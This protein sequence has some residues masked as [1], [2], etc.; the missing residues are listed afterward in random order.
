MFPQDKINSVSDNLDDFDLVNAIVDSLTSDTDKRNYYDDYPPLNKAMAN[1]LFIV[2]INIRSLQKH[3]ESLYEFLNSFDKTTDF[4]CISETRLKQ[5]PLI[6]V[7]LP[8]FQ[9][10]HNDSPTNAGGVAIYIAVSI[11]FEYLPDLQIDI[12]GCENIWIKLCQSNIVIVT[13]YRHPQ[14]DAQTFLDSLDQHLDLLKNNK[15][16]LIGDLNINISTSAS[17]LN[18]AFD[19]LNVLASHGYFPLIA[20][21]TRVTNSS[22]IIIDHI[23]TNDNLHTLKPGV[24][25]ADLSDHYPIFCTISNIASKKTSQAVYQHNFANFKPDEFCTDL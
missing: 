2:H 9:L 8:G 18:C 3:Y 17:R 25:R 6:T 20:I 13:I 21:P 1:D 11:A 15:V 23:I 16:F 14:N 22:A 10:L 7:N 5:G 19:Y 12:K 4:I 24:I